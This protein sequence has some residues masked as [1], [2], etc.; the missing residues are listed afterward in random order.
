VN[1]SEL[2]VA[3]VEIPF[4][5]VTSTVPV[6]AGDVAVIVDPFVTET[7]VAA[8][9]P[10]ETVSPE[11]KFVPVTVTFVPPAVVPEAGLT[12]ETVGGAT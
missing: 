9:P 11:A 7:F 6:P 5:T 12:A 4:E 3:D 2:P 10:N 1:L 8:V